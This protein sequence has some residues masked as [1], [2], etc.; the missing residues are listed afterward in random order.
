MRPVIRTSLTSTVLRYSSARQ[1][2][3]T[4]TARMTVDP[5]NFPFER[6]SGPEPPAEYARLRKTNPVSR[7]KLFDG[8]LAWLMTKH[9]DVT[10][11]ATDSRLSKVCMARTQTTRLSVV[12][13][14]RHGLTLLVVHRCEPAPASPS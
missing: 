9:K 4:A 11:V 5:P 14:S 2:S 1:F 13:R 8:S 3:V 12:V 10:A 7:V 6:A